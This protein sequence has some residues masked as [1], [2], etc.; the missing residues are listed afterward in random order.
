MESRTKED[1]LEKKV[2]ILV[3]ELQKVEDKLRKDLGAKYEAELRNYE[4]RLK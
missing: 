3:D 2:E 4:D 1:F